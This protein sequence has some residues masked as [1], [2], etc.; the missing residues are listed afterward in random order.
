[1][2][3]SYKGGTGKTLFTITTARILAKEFGKK[4]LLVE[5]DF[6]M[7]T[8]TKIFHNMTVDTYFNEYYANRDKLDRY[9]YHDPE[10]KVDVIFASPN[11]HPNDKVIKDDY[12]SFFVTGMKHLSEELERLDYEYVLFDL[13]PGKHLYTIATLK[14]CT[15]IFVLV[16]GYNEAVIDT[17][18]LIE[19]FYLSS[20]ATEEVTS[21]QFRV[22][23]NQVP[24]EENIEKDIE[25][26]MNRIT[27]HVEKHIKQLACFRYQKE[28]DLFIFK[29]DSIMIPT[30][31]SL[32]QK[33]KNI[34]QEII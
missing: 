2:F 21:K 23:L 10:Q 7:P 26:K 3:H 31:D 28:T 13:S 16:R 29:E 1:M 20:L 17:Q 27:K 9:I 14:L 24:D 6:R 12:F 32:Y 11:Y 4:V 34:V 8:Y 18:D 15:D 19:N 22:F 30:S 25:R 33:L 5:T